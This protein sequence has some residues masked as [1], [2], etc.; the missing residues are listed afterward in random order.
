MVNRVAVIFC[1]YLCAVHQVYS[2]I[3]TNIRSEAGVLSLLEFRKQFYIVDFDDNNVLTYD[4]IRRHVLLVDLNNDGQVTHEELQSNPDTPKYPMEVFR[5]LD[6]NNDNILNCT[7]IRGVFELLPGTG[8]EVDLQEFL[9]TFSTRMN[10]TTGPVMKIQSFVQADR[11]FMIID[12]NDDNILTREEFQVDFTEA[13]ENKNGQ[14]EESEVR[15]MFPM[16]ST[17]PET[18]CPNISVSCSVDDVMP[19]FDAADKN[20]DSQLTVDEYIQHFGLLIEN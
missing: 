3:L 7:D 10:E 4:N 8:N 2:A 12:E 13:D 15:N 20:Q 14:L 9:T 5:A 1:V 19:L 18:I 11:D 16:R 17:P 6:I